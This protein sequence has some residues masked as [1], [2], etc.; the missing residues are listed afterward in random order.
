MNKRG[1]S[2]PP[3]PASAVRIGEKIEQL[4]AGQQR[5][6]RAG[7]HL[8]DFRV[9]HR[10]GGE[11]RDIARHRGEL[12]D[13][14]DLFRRAAQPRSLQADFKDRDRLLQIRAPAPAPAQAAR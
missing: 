13:G 4:H 1:I 10:F 12:R 11:H 2:G 9:R 6:A 8:L 3:G 14:R 7:Q 5:F